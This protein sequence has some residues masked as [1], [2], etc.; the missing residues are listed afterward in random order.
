[1]SFIFVPSYP[2]VTVLR[3]DDH[4]ETRC[5]SKSQLS[6]LIMTMVFET[7]WK[8][9]SQNDL[10]IFIG[11]PSCPLPTD[12]ITNE[13]RRQQCLRYSSAVRQK[14]TEQ[15][16]FVHTVCFSGI[17]AW[18]T[19]PANMVVQIADRDYPNEPLSNIISAKKR[20]SFCIRW[21]W[22]VS[23]ILQPDAVE[24]VAYSRA[25]LEC[26]PQSSGTDRYQRE[27]LQQSSGSDQ[28]RQTPFRWGSWGSFVHAY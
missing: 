20:S 17:F 3:H 27:I 28:I 15:K 6:A 9:S 26:I 10:F 7:T 23:G 16:I 21:L 8:T 11:V 5:Y 22:T 13:A 24:L 19:T 1:M 25:G 4:S 14:R 2:N 18:C 12:E